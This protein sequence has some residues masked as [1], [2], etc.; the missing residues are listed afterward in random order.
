MN[1]LLILGSFAFV[2][3]GL[4]V[5]FAGWNKR[6]QKENSKLLAATVFFVFTGFVFVKT[7]GDNGGY[8]VSDG[9]GTK[10]TTSVNAGAGK[11]E[12]NTSTP[13]S[14]S[15][16]TYS[17]EN[18]V[19]DQ[20]LKDYLAYMNGTY[21][22]VKRKI[23][24]GQRIGTVEWSQFQNELGLEVGQK[25]NDDIGYETN[26]QKE[27]PDQLEKRS[28]VSIVWS[29]LSDVIGRAGLYLEDPTTVQD[30]QQS[31]KEYEAQYQKAMSYF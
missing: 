31:E 21:Q 22:K 8:V 16:S 19:S 4:F 3:I 2:A 27:K 30:L 17:P 7:G 11:L 18:P 1:N 9:S 13:A 29:C 15:K 5:T 28:E 25:R 26:F 12:T 6:S 14:D 23:N 24:S 20:F 10:Q